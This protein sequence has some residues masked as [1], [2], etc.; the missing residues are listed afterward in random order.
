MP[1]PQGLDLHLHNITYSHLYK[2]APEL[3]SLRVAMGKTN[4]NSY[5]NSLFLPKHNHYRT[6]EST[7]AG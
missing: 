1:L 5:D 2:Q 3:K 7:A 6:E 4:A